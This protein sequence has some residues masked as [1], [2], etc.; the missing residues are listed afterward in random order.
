MK[1][2]FNK[3]YWQAVATMAGTIIGA[4]ILG[5]PY[6]AS[7]TGAVWAIILLLGL[8]AAT[9]LTNLMVG[10]FILR[11][12]G[13]HQLVGYAKKYLGSWAGRVQMFALMFS[14]Y[15][16]LIAYIIGEGEV[17]SVL[18]GG[19]AFYYS[20]A[21]WVVAAII[22]Y[23]GL[24]LVK[25]VEFWLVLFFIIII[26]AISAVSFGVVDFNNYLYQDA[27]KLFIPYGVILFAYGGASS[28][29]VGR[30]ILK[31]KEKHVKS[32]VSFASW[33]PIL[34]YTVFTLAVLGA[35]GRLTS[36]VATINLSQVI[37]GQVAFWGNV[38]A[39]L[40]M[41]TSFLSFS[42]VLME[43]FHFD[44]KMSKFNSWLAVISLPLVIFLLGARDFITVMGIAGSLTFGLTGIIIVLTFWV[45]RRKGDK[46]PVFELPQLKIAGL[47]LIILFTVGF[48]W[49]LYNMLI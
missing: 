41:A 31:G 21:F 36:E 44:Y 18:L 10:E 20:L 28:V 6:A 45:A 30:E 17:L 1:K 48:V 7:K 38:F 8:G 46:K 24:N 11:T 22:L 29:V 14:T 13:S 42:V 26:A 9:W 2:K 43:V 32:A 16:A 23:V 27:G 47:M 4:G 19:S 49:T 25:V 34:I 39:L 40:G 5:I 12:K 35:T 37:N 3:A 15:G 33:L